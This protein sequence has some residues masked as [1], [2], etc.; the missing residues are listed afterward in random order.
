MTRADHILEKIAESQ[1]MPFTEGRI[2]RGEALK[3]QS[4]A[5]GKMIPHHDHHM[6]TRFLGHG[7]KPWAGH[8]AALATLGFTNK[9]Q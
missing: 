2:M 9:G 8:Q 4:I 1:V 3:H 6:A 5:A 7:L